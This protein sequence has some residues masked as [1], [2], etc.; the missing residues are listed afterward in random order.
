MYS[1]E[2]FDRA[3]VIVLEH[4]GA[5]TDHP[6]DHGGA[7]NFGISSVHHP[8]V[9]VV[10]LT[11]DDAIE[12]YWERYWDGENFE[13]LP[14]TVAIKTFDLAVHMG[15]HGAVSC[16]QR[17][18]RSCGTVVAVDG[19][20]GPETAGVCNSTSHQSILAALRSEAAGQYRVILAKDPSQ[21]A[22]TTGWL[23][24]AYS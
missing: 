20:I 13:L 4:E 10:N 21:R 5:F 3:I 15:R 2:K 14:L 18:L 1:R 12:L 11:R 22:F 24:R 23:N 7:S 8:D 16:L 19:L 17:A 6:E 9:D